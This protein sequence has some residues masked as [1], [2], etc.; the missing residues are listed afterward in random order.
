M[1][2][3]NE[4]TVEQPSDDRIRELVQKNDMVIFTCT[5]YSNINDLRLN[6]CLKTLQSEFGAASVPVVVVDG[7][8]PEVHECLKRCT[9]AIVRREQKIYG[10]GKGGALR[11]AAMIAGSLPGVTKSTFLCWQEAEKSDMMRCWQ[12][13]VREGSNTSD[14]VIC[15]ARDDTCFRN[16]YP[17]EQYHSESYGNYYLNCI[18]KGELEAT[19]KDASGIIS[20]GEIDWHFGPFAFRRQLL[21]LWMKYEGSSYDAQLIPIVAAIRKGHQVNTGIN[22]TFKL[23]DQ[24]KK[25]EEGNLDFIEKRLHQLNDLDPKVKQFWNDELYC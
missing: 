4:A 6:Q 15:P 9:G 19:N 22:V 12:T 18:M 16:S 1:T 17:I 8:P 25:Q 24:M 21:D 5:Y 3:E 11:E 14:E 20:C 10:K 13:E 2:F 23:D 7:S